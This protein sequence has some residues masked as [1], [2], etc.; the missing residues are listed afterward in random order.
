MSFSLS[1]IY[2]FYLIIMCYVHTIC[3]I[4]V[5]LSLCLS[6]LSYNIFII[7]LLSLLFLHVSFTSSS[8]FPPSVHPCL[9]SHM[10]F[11]HGIDRSLS[12]LFLPS[13]DPSLSI[14][15]PFSLLTFISSSRS[16]LLA[17]SS[18]SRLLDSHALMPRLIA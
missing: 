15:P 1:V 6:L 7:F 17:P 12:E 2:P 14:S 13:S 4:C 18:P 9:F 16:L 11:S 10:A 3:L 8:V 5:F